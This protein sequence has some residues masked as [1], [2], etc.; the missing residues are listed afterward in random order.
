VVSYE[1][2]PIW[3][4]KMGSTA[5]AVALAQALMDDGIYVNPVDYAAVPLGWAGIRIANS[6]FHPERHIV[7]LADALARHVPAILDEPEIV[8]DLTGVEVEAD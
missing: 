1:A 6:L 8:I 4:V 2:T 5:K 3:F 7:E